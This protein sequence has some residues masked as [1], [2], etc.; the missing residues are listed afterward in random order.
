MKEL[1][2]FISWTFVL[3]WM[4]LIFYL[5]HQPGDESASL[6]GGV[7]EFALSLIN[8]LMPGIHLA[9]VEWFHTFIRKG[10]HFGAYFIL[11]L[12]VM[13]ALGRSGVLGRK[14]VLLGI[15]TCT[16]Y[17]ISDE[18]HQ[19]FIPGRSGQ[20]SDVLIDSLGACAGIFFFLAIA[21]LSKKSSA[22]K[23]NGA[24]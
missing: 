13:N 11:G 5:S 4:A 15:I 14:R 9:E 23:Q 19:L 18:F 17:A 20:V 16:T 1:R 3:L 7:M 10:A 24:Y 6:S 8:R 12:L 22:K 21:R 2:V